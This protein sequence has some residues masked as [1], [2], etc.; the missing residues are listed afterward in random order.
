ELDPEVR[1]GGDKADLVQ[2]AG[3]RWI[4]TPGRGKPPIQHALASG[5]THHCPSPS[6]VTLQVQLPTPACGKRDV[7][8]IVGRG[9]LPPESENA[10][11]RHGRFQPRFFMHANEAAL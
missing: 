11:P 1:R 7:D 4:S 8:A 2:P 3:V 5:N 9:H 6:R 10:R